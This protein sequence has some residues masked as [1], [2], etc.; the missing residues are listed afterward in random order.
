M[1]FR[2]ILPSSYAEPSSQPRLV[3]DNQ[4]SR[5]SDHARKAG[6]QRHTDEEWEALRPL[7]TQLY[8]NHTL[9]ETIDLVRELTDFQCRER[10][11]RDK[12]KE[13]GLSEKHFKAEDMQIAL[14]KQGKRKREA[15][16]DTAFII[17]GIKVEGSRLANL[18]KRHSSTAE[19]HVSPSAPTPDGV[20]YYTPRPFSIHSRIGTRLDAVPKTINI[21]SVSSTQ[22]SGESEIVRTVLEVT[23]RGFSKD[24]VEKGP[25]QFHPYHQISSTVIVGS[26]RFRKHEKLSQCLW[27]ISTVAKAM[28]MATREDD[29]TSHLQRPKFTAVIEKPVQFS[30][31]TNSARHKYEWDAD[32]IQSFLKTELFFR[33]LLGLVKADSARWQGPWEAVPESASEADMAMAE[34]LF[35]NPFLAYS[36][37]DL[38]QMLVRF[39]TSENPPGDVFLR[40]SLCHDT[41]D[42]VQ[43]CDMCNS[44]IVILDVQNPDGTITIHF[45]LPD[46]ATIE[47]WSNFDNFTSNIHTRS[48]QSLNSHP[49]LVSKFQGWGMARVRRKCRCGRKYNGRDH[50]DHLIDLLLVQAD[51]EVWDSEACVHH[52]M[53]FQPFPTDQSWHITHYEQGYGGD[54]SEASDHEDVWDPDGAKAATEAFEPSPLQNEEHNIDSILVRDTIKPSRLTELSDLSEFFGFPEEKL[55]KLLT[56]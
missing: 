46:S 19:S 27:A 43:N 2:R 25:D 30:I 45:T 26:G 22:R 42:Y 11:F 17:N 6:Q 9:K 21:E 15:G 37:S 55:E 48:Q 18:Y 53:V 5:P 38:V 14:A 13:W 35:G 12:L 8:S 29:G 33:N 7:I 28:A 39:R 24:C 52:E 3:S 36:D 16:L 31:R 34:A 10:R 41:R 44:K 40:V 50:S 4:I 51:E 1:S 23:Y 32:T 54:S 56:D 20:E 47:S 49:E